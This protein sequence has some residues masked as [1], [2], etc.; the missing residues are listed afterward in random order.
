MKSRK[1]F[2]F[3]CAAALTAS[4]MSSA[5]AAEPN[6][7]VIDLGDGYYV[8]E[9]IEYLPLS[10]A[11]DTVNGA[12]TL[13]LY[14]G[15]TLIGTTTLGGVFDTSGSTARATAGYITG[16]GSNGW[17]YDGGSTRCSGNKVSGTATYRSADGV[18]KSHS[19]SIS[20]SPDGK[21]S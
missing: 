5:V 13:K 20:C 1:V 14:L 19:G 12:K 3:L 6:E 11:G 10:R 15:S 8:V 9:T 2:A 7:T 4:L 21:L 16:T 17:S 18:T